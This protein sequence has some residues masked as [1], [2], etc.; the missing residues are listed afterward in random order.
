M[1]HPLNMTHPLTMHPLTMHPLIISWIG[2]SILS[3]CGS[4]QQLW[5]TK[6]EYQVTRP[7]LPC[8]RTCTHY[9]VYNILYCVPIIHP[10][11]YIHPITH[12]IVCTH[13]VVYIYV[14]QMLTFDPFE[15]SFSTRLLSFP[16]QIFRNM[17]VY[18]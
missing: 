13:L 14:V 11:V 10:I 8:F 12:P 4:F 18:P 2:G 1:T 9:H 17:A 15:H 16:I 5:I 6:G 7:P 3:I